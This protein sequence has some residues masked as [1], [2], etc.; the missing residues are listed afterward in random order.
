MMERVLESHS[1]SQ[2]FVYLVYV[3]VSVQLFVGERTAR[4]W[5]GRRDEAGGGGRLS[6][7]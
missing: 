2:P 6:N 5:E 3:H 4:G 7:K 1:R